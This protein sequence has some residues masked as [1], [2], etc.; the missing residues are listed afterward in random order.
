M[1][2]EDEFLSVKPRLTHGEAGL[3]TG[4][5]WKFYLKIGCSATKTPPPKRI[6]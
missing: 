6:E 2:P 1:D 3:L 4:L 5:I